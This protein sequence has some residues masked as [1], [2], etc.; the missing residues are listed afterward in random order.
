MTGIFSSVG[1]V[2]SVSTADPATYD[3]AGFAALTWATCGQLVEVPSFG[4]EA[5]LATHTPLATGIVAKRRGSVNY[6]SLA[7]TMAFSDLDTGQAI[8]RT[9]GEAAPGADSSVSVRVV[10]QNG[11]IQYFTAQVM[12]FKTNIGGADAITMSEVQLEIDN[13]IVKVG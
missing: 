4:H 7:L 6:G 2:V 8:L 10:L 9:A 3:G 12:S 1:T 11:D 5:S 13:R